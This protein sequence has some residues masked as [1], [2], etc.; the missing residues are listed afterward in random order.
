MKFILNIKIKYMYIKQSKHA[1][2][3]NTRGSV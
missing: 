1:K 3:M 2:E